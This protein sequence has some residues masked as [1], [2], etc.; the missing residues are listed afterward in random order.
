MISVGMDGYVQGCDDCM[1]IITRFRCNSSAAAT[2]IA[3]RH[4]WLYDY[5]TFLVVNSAAAKIIAEKIIA[6]R[7]RRLYDYYTFLVVDS[8]TATIIAEKKSKA[9]TVI[10][11]FCWV[12]S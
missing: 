4:R 2:T 6:E 8:A 10:T 11:G 1:T 3:E 12:K 5:Y 7:H 9:T